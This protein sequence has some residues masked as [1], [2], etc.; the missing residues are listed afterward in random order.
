[1]GLVY[2]KVG[3]IL[4]GS[5]VLTWQKVVK[6]AI[7]VLMT[8]C[9]H[10]NQIENGVTPKTPDG[11]EEC[12]QTGDEWMHLRLCLTCGH[13]GCCDSSPNKHARQH[14]EQTHHPVVRTFQSRDDW[15]W[16]YVDEVYLD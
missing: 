5:A 1:V 9:S 6:Q 16:C 2:R 10:V 13:V 8:S 12:L 4:S 11:C 14:F 7:L 15:Q 3:Q